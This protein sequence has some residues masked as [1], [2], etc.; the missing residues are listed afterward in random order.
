MGGRSIGDHVIGTAFRTAFRGEDLPPPARLPTRATSGT[1]TDFRAL[2]RVRRLG[3]LHLLELTCS[4]SV[5]SRTNPLIRRS[6]P[7]LCSVVFPLHG[8]LT[9]SQ[10]G[11]VAVLRGRGLTFYD[12][13]RPLRL[14]ITG[15]GPATLLRADVL[16]SLLPLP[17][18]RIDRLA[19]VL[20]PGRTG[21]GALLTHFLTDLAA[22]PR[23]Y[24]AAD[25]TLLG[26]VALDLLAATLTHHLDTTPAP[27][28]GPGL[29]P[30]IESY[31]RTHLADPDLTPR[32]VAAAHHISVSYLHRL[33]RSRGTTVT[34]LIRHGRLERAR[35]DLADRRLRELPVHRIAARWGFRDHSAF[36]RAFRTAYGVP[37][38][39]FRRTRA[40]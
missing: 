6:D 34:A 25:E 26:A 21:L 11:R 38:R 13:S 36:T 2:A 35:H 33:F 3:P 10:A 31:V 9:V 32:T 18:R 17:A 15:P 20:L 39:E 1:G 19:G 23:A 5:L 12:S 40:Q 28:P 22:D 37:P 24:P 14:R 29:L 16:R 30:R 27:P 8:S 4:P 7:G